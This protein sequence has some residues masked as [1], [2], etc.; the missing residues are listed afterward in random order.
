MADQ[1][2]ESTS[3]KKAPQDHYLDCWGNPKEAVGGNAEI[4]VEGNSDHTGD[5]S[6]EQSRVPKQQ[7][8]PTVSQYP[9]LQKEPADSVP[10]LVEVERQEMYRYRNYDEMSAEFRELLS[11]AARAYELIPQMYNRLTLVEGYDHAGA[12][13]KMYEDHRDLR[14]FSVR[15]IRRYLPDDNP[16]VPRRVRTSRPKQDSNQSD[17][18]SSIFIVETRTELEVGSE[19]QPYIVPLIIEVD[20]VARTVVSVRVDQAKFDEWYYPE[21]SQS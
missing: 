9:E 11:T 14:G 1:A 13:R 2:A 12:L 20:T 18:E 17:Q 19:K 4:P 16:K 3:H 6:A 10:D 21:L 5:S 8:S 7:P 15:N